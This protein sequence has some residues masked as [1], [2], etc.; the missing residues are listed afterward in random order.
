MTTTLRTRDSLG[1]RVRVAG[2]S[3]ATPAPNGGW[4][5]PERGA[6]GFGDAGSDDEQAQQIAHR[7]PNQGDAES[8]R[9][10]QGYGICPGT[11]NPLHELRSNRT[12]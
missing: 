4:A 9:I 6:M 7:A 2:V 10:K 1:L 8:K 11:R 5:S 3:K 12:L